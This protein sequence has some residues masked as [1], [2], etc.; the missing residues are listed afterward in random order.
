LPF[1]T[2]GEGPAV[3]GGIGERLEDEEIER[4]AEQIGLSAS[5]GYCRVPTIL[6]CVLSEINNSGGQMPVGAM[7]RP[8]Y[9]EP[10]TFIAVAA[11]VV[12]LSA[13]IVGIY[14]AALQRAHDRAEVWPHL[15]LSTYV[16]PRGA[17][18]RLE[19]GGIGPAIV[20][21]VIVTV[22]GRPR[23]NW[24]EV[25][26]AITGKRPSGLENSTAA[27]HA[28]RAGDRLILVGVPAAFLPPGLW[29][30]IKRVGVRVCYSSVF[31]ESWILEGKHLGGGSN[32]TSVAKCGGQPVGADF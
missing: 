30:Y 32:W 10:E 17:E 2:L 27:E 28:I 8:W 3:K 26:E 20:H 7:D 11:L 24:D 18:V 6:R 5:H 31:G 1:D 23:H 25:V 13:V 22:D 29:D 16:T 19:N 9:R 21:S 4:A 14:E 15:E 12:S